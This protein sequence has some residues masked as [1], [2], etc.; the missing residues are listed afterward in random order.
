MEGFKRYMKKS[1]KKTPYFLDIP[2]RKVADLCGVT[3]RTVARWADSGRAPVAAERLV[4]A[5]RDGRLV[6]DT[7]AGQVVFLDDAHIRTGTGHMITVAQL[8]AYGWTLAAF[9]QLDSIYRR[10]RRDAEARIAGLEAEIERLKAMRPRC[11]PPGRK[12][13]KLPGAGRPY[14]LTG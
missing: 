7:L 4:E 1:S 11:Q 9:Q 6:P 13:D 2:A 12:P 3:L 14:R 5:F 10:Y 8:E